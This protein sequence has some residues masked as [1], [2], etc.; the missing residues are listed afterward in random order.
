MQAQQSLSEATA[1]FTVREI[2]SSRVMVVT[3]A[4]GSVRPARAATWA[5]VALGGSR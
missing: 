2:K 5:M 1:L 4:I 3:E